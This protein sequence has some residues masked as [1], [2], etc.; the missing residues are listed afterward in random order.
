MK[1]SIYGSSLT[2]QVP[3]ITDKLHQASGVLIDEFGP[4]PSRHP[5]GIIELCNYRAIL[6]VRL[7]RVMQLR[8]PQHWNHIE[9]LWDEHRQNRYNG[10]Y[11]LQ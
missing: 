7:S 5:L 1:T 3:N 11:T 8:L 4:H 2:M 9:I 6:F 10:N